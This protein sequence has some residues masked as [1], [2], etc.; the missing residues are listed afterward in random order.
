MDYSALI[1]PDMYKS[2]NTLDPA[3]RAKALMDFLNDDLKIP[4]NRTG[5]LCWAVGKTLVFFKQEA[6]EKLQGARL[7]QRNAGATVVQA[8]FRRYWQR[9]LFKVIK[10]CA[11]HV[12]GLIRGKEARAELEMQHRARAATRL[13]ATHRK[14]AEVKRLQAVRRKVHADPGDAAWPLGS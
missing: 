9:K 2:L 12:Q 1:S 5:G 14:R 8:H 10:L 7:K 13:G 4:R 6:F 11:V 3:P